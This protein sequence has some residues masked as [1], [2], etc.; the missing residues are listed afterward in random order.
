MLAGTYLAGHGLV[1]AIRAVVAGQS[2][3]DPG[4]AGIVLDRAGSV[5]AYPFPT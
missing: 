3:F 1:R 2:T 5:P 4:V